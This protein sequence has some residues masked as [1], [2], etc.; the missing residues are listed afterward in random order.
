MGAGAG[1]MQRPGRKREEERE[2]V[3]ALRTGVWRTGA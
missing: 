3:R 2:G 1:Q